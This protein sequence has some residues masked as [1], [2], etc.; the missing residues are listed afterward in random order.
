MEKGG[1]PRAT[2]RVRFGSTAFFYNV[3]VATTKRFGVLFNNP[4]GGAED[5]DAEGDGRSDSGPSIGQHYGW[6]HIFRNLDTTKILQITGDRTITDVNIIFML[7]WMSM[8]TEIQI[9]EQR[10][11][12]RNENIQRYS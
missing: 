7:N 1:L 4:N 11:R 12:Q 6:L 2:D 10:E 5:G 9:E 3:R 8:E